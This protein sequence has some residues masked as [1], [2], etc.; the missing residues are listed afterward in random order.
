MK[1]DIELVKSESTKLYEEIIK[2]G[3][4]NQL[5]KSISDDMSTKGGLI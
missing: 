5:A 1:K 4:S 2:T 3:Y